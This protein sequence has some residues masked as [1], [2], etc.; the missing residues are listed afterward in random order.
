MAGRHPYF[1]PLWA[2]LAVLC[3]V[4]GWL[5]ATALGPLAPG[6]APGTAGGA[7]AASLA[8][9]TLATALVG[10]AL[11]A[12][13]SRRKRSD[14]WFG[15]LIVGTL[16]ACGIDGVILGLAVAGVEGAVSGMVLGTC[17]A[18]PLL[19]AV[20]CITRCWDSIG[21]A[22]R[23]SLVDWAQRRAPWSVLAAFS[24]VGTTLAA[25]PHAELLLLAGAMVVA[26]HTLLDVVARRRLA[27]FRRRTLRP[28]NGHIPTVDL[29]L[30]D[31]L[32]A[33]L[34]PPLTPFRSREEPA[35]VLQ[36]NLAAATEAV[37]R[38]LSV[39]ALCVLASFAALVLYL[40]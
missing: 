4:A 1:E 33:E 11:G 9:A 35:W 27:L 29:G 17:L 23:N 24:V 32:Q 14:S 10:A 21:D 39:D 19:P 7:S 34:A 20:V 38:A 30:G 13:L 15:S 26:V 40:G 22:R 8:A 5:V 36:G 2:L 3:A 25:P 18:L 12:F 37:E 6:I 31:E 16:I 28:T